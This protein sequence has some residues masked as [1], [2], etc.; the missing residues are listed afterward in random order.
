MKVSAYR[1]S[2]LVA[3]LSLIVALGCG[4][5]GPT[6]PAPANIVGSWNANAIDVSGTDYAAEGMTL[7]FT[8]SSNGNYSYNVVND[9][10]G[11]CDFQ[12]SNCNESGVFIAASGQ[13]TFDPDTEWEET[14]NYSV[15]GTTLRIHGTI[16]GFPIDATFD[17][18]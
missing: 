3:C 17:K 16:W 8:F 10:L 13:L 1:W 2:A 7:S 15:T 6:E 12:V 5:D 14:L 9:L 18:Q 4:S 11:F